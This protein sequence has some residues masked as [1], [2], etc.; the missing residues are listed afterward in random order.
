MDSNEMM[1]VGPKMSQM[2]LGFLLQ[3]SDLTQYHLLLLSASYGYKFRKI[4]N[5]LKI[6]FPSVP[7]TATHRPDFKW[8]LSYYSPLDPC[9]PQISS[10]LIISLNCGMRRSAPFPSSQLVLVSWIDPPDQRR[11]TRSRPPNMRFTCKLLF[12]YFD[13]RLNSAA[14]ASNLDD[15]LFQSGIGRVWRVAN[16]KKSYVTS[17]RVWERSAGWHPVGSSREA[18][19]ADAP[20]TLHLGP[21]GRDSPSLRPSSR[22][23]GTFLGPRRL[24]GGG[25][26]VP[27]RAAISGRAGRG[28]VWRLASCSPSCSSPRWV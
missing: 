23:L 28:G 22:H 16:K 15:L 6:I 13:L 2:V 11:A 7:Q 17:V 8:E 1:S 9:Q 20:P 3:S 25:G 19:P 27:R 26:R 10:C 24:P 14:A 4:L 18:Q 21:L 12:Y 5:S